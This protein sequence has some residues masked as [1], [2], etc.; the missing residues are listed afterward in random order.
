MEQLLTPEDVSKALQIPVKT[1]YR[2]RHNGIGPAAIRVG[3]HLRYRS[4]DVEAWITS[5][6]EESN[7]GS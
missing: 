3:R 2:W 4:T 6:I 5:G 1:L 7:R